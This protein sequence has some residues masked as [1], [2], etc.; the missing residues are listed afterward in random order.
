[1]ANVPQVRAHF[2]PASHSERKNKMPLLIPLALIGLLGVGTYSFSSSAGE[3]AGTAAGTGI[4]NA[5]TIVGIAAGVGI[6]I[7]AVHQK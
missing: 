4:G 2:Q 1:M 7:Y 5:V 3:A 6:I